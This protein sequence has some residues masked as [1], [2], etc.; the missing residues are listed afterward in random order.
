MKGDRQS[1]R[2]GTQNNESEDDQ[3]PW[4]KKGGKDREDAGNV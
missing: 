4:G 1:P 2:K 3:G